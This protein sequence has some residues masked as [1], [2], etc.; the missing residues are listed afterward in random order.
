MIEDQF[1]R[2]KVKIGEVYINTHASAAQLQ[3][4]TR[5]VARI[6]KIGADDFEF[7]IPDDSSKPAES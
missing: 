1:P 6:G 7:V 5:K 3:D 4:W 2:S